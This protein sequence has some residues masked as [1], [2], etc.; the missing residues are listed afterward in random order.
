[1]TAREQQR[2]IMR[3]L[4]VAVGLI[5]GAV[6][7]ASPAA[8]SSRPIEFDANGGNGAPA[9]Q[10]CDSGTTVTLSATTP[11]RDG[12]TFTGWNTAADGSGTALPAATSMACM[13]LMLFAQWHVNNGSV[14]FNG[15]GGNGAGAAQS[16]AMGNVITLSETEPTRSGYWFTGWNTSPDGSGRSLAPGVKHL[17][18]TFTLYAQWTD[19]PVT[20]TFTDTV[21]DGGPTEQHCAAGTTVMLTGRVPTSGLGSFVGWQ[22]TGTTPHYA[23]GSMIDCQEVTLEADWTP[24]KSGVVEITYEPNGGDGASFSVPCES[25]TATAIIAG[26]PTRQG[27]IFNNWT[28]NQ[29][30]TGTEY[31]PSNVVVCAAF[32]VWAQWVTT[33]PSITYDA[34]GGTSA[35]AQQECTLNSTV[36]LSA[37]TPTR[38]G[39][40][41]D[42]W[43]FR[44]DGSPVYSPSASITCVTLTLY[45]QWTLVTAIVTYDA[46]EGFGDPGDLACTADTP[47]TL[48]TVT[49][50]RTGYTFSGWN[51]AVDGTGTAYSA[52]QQITCTNL[53]L[54][55]QWTANGAQNLVVAYDANGGTGD[56]GDQSC[57]AGGTLTL[58]TVTPTRDGFTFIGWNTS[59]AGTGTTYAAGASATC[60]AM[61]LYAAWSQNVGSSILSYDANGGIGDPPDISCTTGSSVTIS[62]TVPVRD[63][64]QFAG[65]NTNSAATGATYAAGA[66]ITCASITLYAVW[67]VNFAFQS[68][69]GEGAPADST[70]TSGQTFTLSS[71]QPTRE[72]YTF[73]GWNTASDGSGTAY[74]PGSTLE[75]S[76]VTLYAQWLPILAATPAI[77]LTL[78]ADGEPAVTPTV[79]EAPALAATGLDM[80]AALVVLLVAMSAAVSCGTVAAS[81]R[82]RHTVLGP[83]GRAVV[84]R[85]IV[86]H[87]AL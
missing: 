80:R 62:G 33:S 84:S 73:T 52:G 78:P 57:L 44:A 77:T 24:S 68:T 19:S 17:C 40:T 43:G 30:G 25:G 37:S 71:T 75:C 14:A 45:A 11:T 21:G 39:H 79:S 82:R 74:P 12:Y 65:W 22:I 38:N 6:V 48:S 36:T 46:N 26:V 5:F 56:P 18:D 69:G 59:A 54:Y 27:Y 32:T 60:A 66:T 76:G 23:P 67:Q 50:S 35:P 70:C 72:G 83:S 55:A 58:S 41:F 13:G 34:N 63:G 42:G 15:N 86:Q 1:M 16:C 53:N 51:T 8:A 47:A 31:A 10:T 4:A 7:S 29:D 2:R 81:F 49:P 64:Y 20:I 61:T 85:T 9:N 28:A 3:P 87:Q